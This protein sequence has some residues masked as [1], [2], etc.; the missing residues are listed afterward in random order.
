MINWTLPIPTISEGN[1]SEHWSVRRKR[2]IAQEMLIKC[3]WNKEKPGTIDLP[4]IV[5]LTRIGKRDL[6]DDNLRFALK[7][8]RD[9]VADLIRPGYPPGQADGCG[10]IKWEY[11]QERGKLRAVRIEILYAHLAFQTNDH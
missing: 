10:L 4:C 9:V 5:K 11:D 7:H 2:H 1:V 6:D 8:V 3:R